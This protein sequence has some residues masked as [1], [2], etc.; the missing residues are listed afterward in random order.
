MVLMDILLIMLLSLVEITRLWAQLVRS[1][2]QTLCVTREAV[3]ATGT[4]IEQLRCGDR[5]RSLVVDALLR[6]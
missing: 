4:R 3:P 1:R 2:W 6:C 5:V